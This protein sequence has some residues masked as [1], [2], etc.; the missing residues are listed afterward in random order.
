MDDSSFA[1]V[2]VFGVPVL[3]GVAGGAPEDPGVEEEDAGAPPMGVPKNKLLFGPVDP[4]IDID[5]IAAFS[6]M[7]FFNL[8]SP[9]S[10]K[11]FF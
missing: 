2:G 1:V 9:P 5:A 8:A 4:P 7:S 3:A 10:L 11:Q 6:S